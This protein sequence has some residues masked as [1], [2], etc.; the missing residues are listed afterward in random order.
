MSKFDIPQ[1]FL[2]LK[3]DYTYNPFCIIYK[4]KSGVVVSVVGKEKRKKK[5]KGMNTF[6]LYY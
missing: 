6:V 1:L 4:K 2:N 5:K 3:F